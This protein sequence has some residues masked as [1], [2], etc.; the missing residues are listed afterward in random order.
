MK[1]GPRE[2]FRPPS[3]R[4]SVTALRRTRSGAFNLPRDLSF[5]LATL[6]GPP[7]RRRLF[8]RQP[9]C[10]WAG[11]RLRY[12]ARASGLTAAVWFA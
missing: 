3:S 2:R 5:A 11:S 9:A 4:S 8:V 7:P 12:S 10:G 6:T 1:A